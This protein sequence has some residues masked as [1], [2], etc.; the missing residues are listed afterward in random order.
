MRRSKMLLLNTLLLTAAAM[1]MRGVGVAFQV[2]LSDKIGS[3]GIGLFGLISSAHMLAITF[4]ASGIRYATTRLV[5]EEL[6]MGRPGGVRSAVM[7]ALAYALLFGTA[8]SICLYTGAEYIG[9]IWIG[10][11][12]TILSLKILSLSL[13]FMSMTSVFGGYF[14][15]VQRV[16][17]SS[18]VQVAEHLIRISVV[19]GILILYPT[20]NLEYACAAVVIGGVLAEFIAFF[21]ILLLY[22]LDLRKI[23]RL[24][25]GGTKMTRRLLNIA[26]PIALSSYARSALS[27]LEHMLIPRGL[28]K[29]GSSYESALADY[30][31]VHGMVFPLI[32]FPTALFSSLGE[33]IIPELTAAQ[34]AGHKNRIRYLVNRILKLCA[35]FSIGI[36]GIFLFYHRELGGIIYKSTDVSGYI[37]IFSFL[38]PVIYLDL[39]T[40]G[41]LKGLGQQLHSMIYNIA[42]SLIS[43]VLVYV[44]LPLY[45][46]NAY[47]CIIF[48]TECFNFAL[49]IRRISKITTLHIT[50]KEL[51][52]PAVCIV[53]AVNFTMLLLRA[54]GLALETTI[55]SIVLHIILSAALYF[56]LLRLL[57]CITKKDVQW[58]KEI[59]K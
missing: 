41:M 7:R 36:A 9:N 23:P 13:P 46:M 8:S 58:I 49:S 24:G 28:K 59:L 57:S 37:K 11:G 32:I 5:S 47:I 10:D 50:L 33:L 18:A 30:G 20:E 3:A 45:A 31:V 48:F 44:F 22:R 35:V 27:T 2:Y 21:L 43:V 52:L 15:A 1:L 34:M 16:I 53:G 14:T 39:I 4:A 6:G 19:V 54:V 40:D 29:S 12:R 55:I 17:K 26:L 38:I 56:F 51:L 42:D 25:A